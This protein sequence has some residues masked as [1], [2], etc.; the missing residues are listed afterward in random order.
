MISQKEN[1]ANSSQSLFM[2]IR[3]NSVSRYID[4]KADEEK[5]NPYR[6]EKCSKGTI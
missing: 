2:N 5:I 3:L 1:I 4:K 6:N